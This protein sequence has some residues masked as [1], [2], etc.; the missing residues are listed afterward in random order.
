MIRVWPSI[1]VHAVAGDF[2][3]D[4]SLSHVGPKQQH[5]SSRTSLALVAGVAARRLSAG[6]VAG[7]SAAGYVA[8]RL[9]RQLAQRTSAIKHLVLDDSEE[10]AAQVRK[11]AGIRHIVQFRHAGTVSLQHEQ[12][13]PLQAQ[14]QPGVFEYHTQWF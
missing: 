11:H 12:Q 2:A 8:A 13:G 14:L 5:V 10:E 9:R 1:Q 6:V 4:T 7:V 3:D